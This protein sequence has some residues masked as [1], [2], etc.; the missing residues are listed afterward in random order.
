MV[1]FFVDKNYGSGDPTC[2][3]CDG[4]GYIRY[5]VPED[6]P[7][8]GRIFDCECRKPEV[9]K[10]KQSRLRRIGGLQHLQD[11]TFETFRVQDLPLPDRHIRSLDL[12]FNA[13]LRFAENPDGWLILVGGYGCGKTHLAAA[14]ANYQIEHDQPVIFVTAPDLLDHL[15]AAYS[16]GRDGE[17]YNT[18]F[19]EVRR[20]P[21]LILDDLGIESPTPWAIEKLYQIMNYRYNAQLPTVVTTNYAIN[22]LEA[23]LS[24]RMADPEFAYNVKITAPDYRRSGSSP[25][26]GMLDGMQFYQ[27][28]TFNNFVI[29][30][31][32]PRE[33]RIN[34]RRAVEF[35]AAYAQNPEGWLVLFGKYGRGKTHLAAAIA[36]ERAKEDPGIIFVTVPDLLDHLRAT[37]SPH[38]SVSYDKRFQEIKTASLLIL[39]DLGTESATP[40]AREKLYQLFNYR[41]NG[42]MPTVVTSSER[43][44]DL[45]ERLITRLLDKRITTM[46][47]LKGRLFTG[48]DE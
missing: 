42:R 10:A 4:V 14:I 45:D 6:H 32:I 48:E 31:D 20:T 23:R 8:F 44:T 18:R 11:K 15:R 5:N 38:S 22:E 2:P 26:D 35:A 12:A 46:F 24:S 1:E 16:P 34:N 47:I 17:T 33:E 36:N 41:Y 25:P 27:H 30:N 19:D 28:M 3:V 40:W 9:A 29:P 21:L 37:Y 43:M 13:A 7:Y 39:D